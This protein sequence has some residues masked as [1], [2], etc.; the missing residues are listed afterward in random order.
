MIINKL[1]G[2]WTE[3]S[4][5]IKEEMISYILE[6]KKGLISQEA[7]LLYNKNTINHPRY[8]EYATAIEITNPKNKR[9]L[10][11]G[12]LNCVMGWFLHDKYNCDVT[13]VGL[14]EADIKNFRKNHKNFGSDK[15]NGY[16]QD[17]RNLKLEE[18]FDIVYSI[19]AIEH[20]REYAKAEKAKDWKIGK[21]T[22]W[23]QYKEAEEYCEQ[24]EIDFVKSLA[25]FVND[26]GLLC[27]TFA[28]KNIDK[29]KC[30]PRCA[31]FRSEEDVI[32]RIVQHTNMEVVGDIDYENF[33]KINCH[34][35]ASTGIILL[36]K[37][38]V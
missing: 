23:G 31:Y 26:N 2:Q 3:E 27:I 16:C 10:D 12:G 11:V 5:K 21:T 29:W 32:D 18:K 34:P 1:I 17:I 7:S 35:P 25:S 9:I 4:S 24:K 33:P 37:K 6:E 38:N 28:Y 36:E 19:N 30:Q 8:W 13:Q 20:V 14:D 15:I 22:Y